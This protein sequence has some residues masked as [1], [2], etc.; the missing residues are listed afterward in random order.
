MSSP[1]MSNF[2]VSSNKIMVAT[3]ALISL[4]LEAPGIKGYKL[5]KQICKVK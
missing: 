2:D 3:V 4:E 1:K 5:S